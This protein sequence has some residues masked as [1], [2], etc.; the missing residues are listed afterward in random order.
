VAALPAD[1][2]LLAGLLAGDE[3]IFATVVRAWSPAMLRVA[4][5]HV[6][7]GAVA[8]EVVQETW[9]AVVT[10][11]AGFEGRAALKT[12][13]LRICANVAR[14]S[15]AREGRC[16]PIGAPTDGPTVD[17]G[18]FRGPEDPYPGHWK[19]GAEPADWGPESHALSEEARRT[20]A[21]AIQGLPD[22]YAHVIALRD[23]HEVPTDEVAELLGTTTGNVRVLVHR[24]RAMLR[25]RL[26]DYYTAEGSTA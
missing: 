22:R 9:L 10:H 7:S 12:W 11:L 2:A 17:P 21:A 16:V 18:R 6:G 8:E 5:Y 3:Q 23:I 1:E 20:L 26:A 4:R 14:R 13:V 19:P 24:A 25:E 15:G